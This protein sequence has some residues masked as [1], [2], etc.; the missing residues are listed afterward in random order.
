LV[1]YCSNNFYAVNSFGHLGYFILFFIGLSLAGF[2]LIELFF[3][4]KK[5]LR[6]YR[7]H[8]LFI[9]VIMIT[10]SLMSYAIK[11]R[12]QKKLLLGILVV[13]KCCNGHIIT[14]NYFLRVEGL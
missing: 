5:D 12:L 11:L 10:A 8:A 1:F 9:A 13:F 4:I 7:P 2:M 14:R 6:K 3:T